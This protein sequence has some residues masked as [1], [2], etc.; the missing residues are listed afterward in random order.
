MADTTDVQ[1]STTPLFDTEGSGHLADYLLSVLEGTL[2]TIVELKNSPED[3][4]IVRGWIRGRGG[5]ERNVSLGEWTEEAKSR[6]DEPSKSLV[7]LVLGVALLH[8]HCEIDAAAAGTPTSSPGTITLAWSHIYNAF[9]SGVLTVTPKHSVQGCLTVPLYTRLGSDGRSEQHLDLRVWLSDMDRTAPEL[10]VYSNKDWAQSW[11]LAGRGTVRTY[12]VEVLDEAQHATATHAAYEHC[13]V[14]SHGTHQGASFLVKNAGELVHAVEVGS[15]LYRHDAS[16]TMPRDSWQRTEVGPGEIYATLC[17]SDLSSD[18]GAST[19]LL[20]PLARN[21]C[22]YPHG[23]EIFPH[24]DIVRAV[25]AQRRFDRLM[26]EGREHASRADWETAQRAIQNA[27]GIYNSPRTPYEHRSRAAALAELGNIARRFGRY[28]RAR[29]NFQELLS[30]LAESEKRPSTLRAEINGELGVV[31]RHLGRLAEAKA[32]FEAQYAIGQELRW[33]R[34]MCRAIGNLGM[35]NYQLWQVSHEGGLLDEAIKQLRERVELARRLMETGEGRADPD[36]RRLKAWE[37]IGLSRLSLCHIARGD[38]HEAVEAGRE[39]LDCSHESDDPTVVAI[40]RLFYGRALLLDGRRDEALQEFN[41]MPAGTCTPAMALCKEPSDEYRG[42]LRELLDDLDVK[43]DV[44]DEHGYSAL[45]YAVFSN[46]PEAQQIIVENLH[47]RLPADQ[48]DRL[49]REAVLRKGYREI[50]QESLRPVLLQAEG[51]DHEGLRCLRSAYSDAL[52]AEQSKAAMFDRLKF[53]H[54][55]DF[56]RSGTLPWSTGGLARVFDPKQV[57]ESDS[58]GVDCIV[59]FSYVWCHRIAGVP[60]PDDE[61]NTQYHR[62]LAAAETFLNLHPSVN[63]DKLGIWIDV[64]CVDQDAPD[65]GVNALLFNLMQCDAVI[66][67][68]DETYYSRAWC[69]VE[70]LM[71]QTLRLAW[72]LHLWYV[73]DISQEKL[74]EGPLDFE[75]N[76]RGTQLSFEQERPMIEFLERQS[77]LLG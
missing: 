21:E 10:G 33:E 34:E 36:R 8:Q 49:R 45:D 67:L 24:M 25:D 74:E 47:R 30:I 72:R 73:Y 18:S 71:V 48:V 3:V 19:T 20:G 58:E 60:S 26:D 1:R 46:D 62:M 77:K 75:V 41:P 27:I 22:E 55:R 40:T 43:L 7:N 31:L 32:A 69:S 68:V 63:P 61:H 35:I 50:F 76:M 16:Y 29:E 15:N 53:V 5:V 6:Q 28:E 44:V 51:G 4:E 23:T 66:S 2:E 37:T 14:R 59:F 12:K 64:A 38:I 65:A 54:Y 11:V 57:A 13:T 52:G 42:Y 39:S 17:L 56:K 9:T 70:V